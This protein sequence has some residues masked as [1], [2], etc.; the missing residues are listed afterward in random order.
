MCGVSLTSL[1]E[2][3]ELTL[4]FRSVNHPVRREPLRQCAAGWGV[5]CAGAAPVTGVRACSTHGPSRA[6]CCPSQRDSLQH[7]HSSLRPSQPQTRAATSSESA[8][9]IQGLRSD[10]VTARPFKQN[11][12]PTTRGRGNKRYEE[13]LHPVMTIETTDAAPY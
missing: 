8:R 12:T 2:A 4:P 10:P 7:L 11:K 13:A 3:N 1:R 9:M 5:V 6:L